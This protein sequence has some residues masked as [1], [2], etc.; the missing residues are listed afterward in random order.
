MTV[1]N[2]VLPRIHGRLRWHSAIVNPAA[3][4]RAELTASIDLTPYLIGFTGFTVDQQ[5][6]E[7][8]DV[9]TNTVI[10]R[11]GSNR[12]APSALNFYEDLVSTSVRTLLAAGTGG[13]VLKMPYGDV[14]G[15][16]IEVW[17]VRTMVPVTQPWGLEIKPAT[18]TVPV[19]VLAYPTLGGVI[20]AA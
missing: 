6:I 5:V 14:P 16:R 1:Y 9:I 11:T 3:P 10:Q 20:P 15:R 4:T 17:R 12:I 18:F 13:V 2:P 7:I 8:P 19:A